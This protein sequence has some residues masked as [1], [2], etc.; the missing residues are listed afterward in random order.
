MPQRKNPDRCSHTAEVE[1]QVERRHYE[2]RISLQVSGLKSI[3]T[4]KLIRLILS[5]ET[6]HR[7]CNL[8]LRKRNGHI[9]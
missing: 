6:G 7:V 4:E 1:P 2:D 3:T 8:T 9:M 5:A